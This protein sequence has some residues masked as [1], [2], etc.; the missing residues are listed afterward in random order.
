M[1]KTLVGEE[2]CTSV[3]N[4]E[5]ELA[6]LEQWDVLT[7][8]AKSSDFFQL[9]CYTIIYVLHLDDT[10]NPF[11]TLG[12]IHPYQSNPAAAIKLLF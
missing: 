10:F 6:F 5:A 9:L 7:T 11:R 1:S 8:V 12:Q 2:S 4:R 3:E